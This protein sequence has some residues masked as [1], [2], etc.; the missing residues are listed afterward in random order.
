MTTRRV[1]TA[2]VATV[3]TYPDA[4]RDVDAPA[5][6]DIPDIAA[7]S[8][9]MSLDVRLGL[10]GR[11][12]TQ[13]LAGEPVEVVAEQGL[14][15]Q[16]RLPWQPGPDAGGY[17]GWVRTCHLG[18]MLPEAGEPVVV[19][20]TPTTTAVTADGTVQLSYATVLRRLTDARI[21]VGRVALRLADGRVG[22]VDAAAVELWPRPLNTS[23]LLS[24][25]R[26]HVGLPYLWGGTSGHGMD[27]SG[28]VHL[29]LRTYGV[30]VPRDASDQQEALTPVDVAD[31]RSGDVYFFAPPDTPPTHVGWVSRPGRLLHASEG[32]D[33]EDVPMTPE[34]LGTL[35]AAAR[36]VG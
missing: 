5:A 10:H 34:R 30:T 15:S 31:V 8:S 14:W 35:V 33:V 1:V 25:V 32:R 26:R 3:W 9:A 12:D 2:S 11:V 4:P 22:H 13:A 20:A 7:W 29:T 24:S 6:A 19:T 21:P 18:P 28:L 17:P 36:P 27:C 16:V 23:A